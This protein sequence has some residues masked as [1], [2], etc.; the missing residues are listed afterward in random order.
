VAEAKVD[1]E[2]ITHE[3]DEAIAIQPAMNGTKRGAGR[4]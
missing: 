2:S 4:S 3:F 1:D